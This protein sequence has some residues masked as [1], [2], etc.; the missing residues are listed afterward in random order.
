MKENV[1]VGRLIPAGTG[2][3]VNKIK[4]VAAG[5]DREILEK[6]QAEQAKLEAERAEAEAVA[7]AEAELNADVSADE[8]A[9]G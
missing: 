7:A 2:A 9:A 1:I 6:Q 5:R 4:R 3:Y 8:A